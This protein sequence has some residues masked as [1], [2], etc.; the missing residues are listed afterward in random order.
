MSLDR[1]EFSPVPAT[2]DPWSVAV[3]ADLAQRAPRDLPD[4]A[5][6][7]LGA[8]APAAGFMR[9]E[10]GGPGTDPPWL[11][12]TARPSGD[13]TAAEAEGAG[14]Q[15]TVPF[16]C[17]G[18]PAGQVRFFWAAGHTGVPNEAL[19]GRLAP[20]AAGIGAVV[21]RGWAAL[22]AARGGSAPLG[23]GLSP[24]P[25]ASLTCLS[26]LSNVFRDVVMRT[27]DLVV[28]TDA[29]RR[30]VWVNPAFEALTG[31]SL[32]EVRGQDPGRLLRNGDTA[33][34]TLERIRTALAAGHGVR[35]EVRNHTRDGRSYWVDLDIQPLHDEGNRLTGFVS[36]QSD[37]TDRIALAERLVTA[38]R[39]ATAAHVRLAN[40]LEALPDPMALFDADA[41]LVIANDAWQRAYAGAHGPLSPGTPLEQVLR[42]R[43]PPDASPETAEALLA[44]ARADLCAPLGQREV[45]GPG[46][47][48]WR[49]LDI[50]TAN[51]DRLMVRIEITHRK[52]EQAVLKDLA[53]Q[54]AAARRFLEGAIAVL[55]DAFVLFDAEDRL[56]LC[57]DRYREV[58]PR[59]TDKMQPGHTFEELLRTAVARGEMADAIGRE[60]A[61]IAERLARFHQ[62]DSDI[63]QRLSDGRWLRIIE[64]RLP[65]G[66][67]V[68]M[69]I[70]ITP[71]KAAEQRLAGIIEGAQVAT[72]EWL[73]TSGLTVIDDRW[74]GI[75][76]WPP[77]AL[78]GLDVA[79]LRGLV[80]PEDRA[81]VHAAAQ[82]VLTGREEL[83]DRELRLR[84]GTGRWIW[85]QARGRVTRRD[86]RGR[87]AS[88]AGVF[89]D[90]TD[91]KMLEMRLAAER[92]QLAQLMDTSVSGIVAFDLLG[93]VVFCNREAERILG[94]PEGA[95]LPLDPEAFGL[96]TESLDGRPFPRA[97][98]AFRQ[99]LATGR[100]VRDVRYAIVSGDGRRR[101]LSVNAAPLQRPDT[102]VAVVCTVADIT[103]QLAAEEALRRALAEE[104]RI[105][106]RFREVS[107]VGRSWVWEQDAN[108]RYTYQSHA[109]QH[110][111]GRTRAQIM[112][113]TRQEVYADSPE[114]FASADWGWLEAQIAARKPFH[115]FTYAV[116]GPGGQELW[117]Q[118]NGRPIFDANG[119]FVGYRGSGRDVTGH[120]AARLAAEAANRT[121]SEFLANMS[122]EIRTP[123]NGVLGMAELLHD[124]VE[125]P[126]SREM[127][128]QIRDSGQ[129]LL[130]IL[131]DILDMSKIEA[132]KLSLEVVA[133]DP[134]ALLAR[135][136]ALHAPVAQERGLGLELLCDP[137][138]PARRLGD[139]HR[140]QQILHN[141]LSNALRF[142]PEGRVRVQLTAKAGG[143]LTC[144]ITDTGIGMGPEQLGRLFR[145]FEQ[146]DRSTS[147]RFGGTGLGTSI[148]KKL[149][150]LMDG[151]I[152]V[153][154]QPGAGTRVRVSL[155]LPEAP[156]ADPRP[157]GMPRPAEGGGD[158]AE[159][160]AGLHL[161]VADDNLTNRRL[162]ELILQQAGATLHLAEH[163][164]AA[165]EAW[166]PGRFDALLLDISMPGMDGCA[167]LAAIRA[168]A[169]AAGAPPPPALAIT[170]N[171]M[172]H[173]V[174]E[175]RIAGFDGHVAK[176]FRRHDLIAAV[177][178]LPGLR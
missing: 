112:G 79:K 158:V 134:A 160:L 62:A 47:R 65:D 84:H 151:A 92:Q 23:D 124:R 39:N 43:I 22:P 10:V 128:A 95:E 143:P 11:V 148:V 129:H 40:A 156:A 125:D 63:E 119:V 138:D 45:A 136:G 161:L 145:P 111:I 25:I 82:R 88:F 74:S 48:W 59:C 55:P 38:E 46:G 108:L 130:T 106:E 9:A 33:P 68:G 167:A 29:H 169:E 163:G 19:R 149:V 4:A 109:L 150:D 113:K 144:E 174:A 135:V 87:A 102:D 164:A 100:Q 58:Y 32:A 73:S 99:V 76:G 178:A 91:R 77:E 80:H 171:A 122:H 110:I 103:D 126:A 121:K 50:A 140:L 139:P 52:Q 127:A 114:V 30:I 57:N 177:L 36:V 105:A 154:S 71:L 41:R 170:A 173:Q 90:I 14:A 16:A 2:G 35:A 37:I 120:F 157:G 15:V 81:G 78:A 24:R 115:D 75:L 49:C 152:A 17:D 146:A 1:A 94:I 133:F 85:V 8:L 18:R 107:E 42:A 3:L 153:D 123:L 131:N 53:D 172:T 168:A 137:P 60:E 12:W 141:L 86:R 104:A 21:A 175:Y 83:F 132:G 69:R 44:Q 162:L 54:A 70:D 64:R 72:W 27:T 20:I 93:R 89:L 7:A 5:A 98:N 67:R 117:I 28:V 142:T 118:I 31:W 96:R 176:P 66:S 166:T 116:P 97:A 159:A 155:P 165:V 51:R 34:Q 101:C 26:D 147:R 61:F 56:V 13:S 6:A